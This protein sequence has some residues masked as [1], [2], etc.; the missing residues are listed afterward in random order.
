M[1]E[2]TK[3][4]T[5]VT[6]VEEETTV[7]RTKGDTAMMEEEGDTKETERTIAGKGEEEAITVEGRADR[8]AT[9]VVNEVIFRGSVLDR[10][11][12]TIAITEVGADDMTVA[13]E[14]EEKAGHSTWRAFTEPRKTGSI[15]PFFSKLVRVDTETDARVFTTS[16][17]SVRL[18]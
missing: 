1:V 5:V 12:A 9:I 17:R 2:R 6:M 10:K 7:E 3:E 16:R 15:A 8:R 13:G 11:E 18:C 4:D 14:R